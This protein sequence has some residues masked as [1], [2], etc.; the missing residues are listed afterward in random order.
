MGQAK[1]VTQRYYCC[2][3]CLFINASVPEP[4]AGS[5]AVLRVR[6]AER[7]RAPLPG[8]HP[9]APCP[10]HPSELPKLS[11]GTQIPPLCSAMLATYYF[12]A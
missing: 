7:G 5:L 1:R 6:D 10:Q 3:C 12:P 2:C 8:S 11:P 9:G 4:V